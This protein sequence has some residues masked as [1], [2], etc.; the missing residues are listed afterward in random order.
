MKIIE[1]NVADKK[2][3]TKHSRYEVK[4]DDCRLPIK[5]KDSKD[6]KVWEFLHKNL[7]D[8]QAFNIDKIDNDQPIGFSSKISTIL[9]EVLFD[10]NS[11]MEDYPYNFNDIKVKIELEP[12]KVD[13]KCK[14][15]DSEAD[16]E[17]TYV[18]EFG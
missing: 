7:V 8:K 14:I 2:D 17:I 13:V 18:V 6:E 15:K 12:R 16:T 10:C 11:D 9:P 1:H 5:L 4:D 3:W